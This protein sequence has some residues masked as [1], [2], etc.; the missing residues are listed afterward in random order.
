MKNKKIII[1]V[2]AVLAAVILGVK[3]KGLLE[4]RKDAI[5]NEAAPSVA[6]ISVEVVKAKQDT[7]KNL[8]SYTAQIFSDKS[9]KLSTKLAGYVKE[10]MVEEAQKVKKGELLVTI[11]AIELQSNIQAL[12]STLEAQKRDVALAQSIYNRNKKLYEIGGLAK[13][14]VDISKV[15][16]STKRSMLE[17]SRQKIAQLKHQLSYLKIVAPFDGVIDAVLLHEGDLAATGKPIIAMSN[18]D[19]KLIFSYAPSEKSTIMIDQIVLF[20]DNQ[21][22]KIKSIYP[23]SKN[24]LISAEVSLS[25]MLSYPVGTNINIDILTQEK[26]GC[27]L[28]ADT[29]IHKQEGTFIMIEDHDSFKPMKVRVEIEKKDKIIVTPC[30]KNAVARGSEVKLSKLQ[31]YDKVNILGGVDAK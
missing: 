6:Q 18:G 9:I 7:L 24:G 23:T 16:L 26:Q 29:L 27:L 12:T 22:G 1:T 5:S 20:N 30:P 8:L 31:A 19:K 25:K 13:E 3:G 11:D 4:K 2:I 15:T 21:I 10:V 14:R 17:S 28:P